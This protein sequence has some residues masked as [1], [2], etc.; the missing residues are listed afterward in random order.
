[1][2]KSGAACVHILATHGIF[3]AESLAVIQ[4]LDPEFV[5]S[6]TV[7]NSIPQTVSKQVL[8]RRLSVIDISGLIAEVIR[9]HHYCESISMISGEFQPVAKHPDLKGQEGE[10]RNLVKVIQVGKN[11]A[12]ERLRKGYRLSSKCWD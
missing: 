4:R 11:K 3:S 5:L 7:T 9:R 10:D 1:M 8:G 12:V 2:R 6:I